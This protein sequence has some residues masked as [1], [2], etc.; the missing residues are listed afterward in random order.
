MIND[1]SI[2]SSKLRLFRNFSKLFFTFLGKEAWHRFDKRCF[3]YFY[4]ETAA[5]AIVPYNE[6]IFNMCGARN[7]NSWIVQRYLLEK[8][9][10]L[11]KEVR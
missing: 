9:I 1:Y 7:R 3:S 8:E 4:D 6:V 2:A 5:T 11:Y 10:D